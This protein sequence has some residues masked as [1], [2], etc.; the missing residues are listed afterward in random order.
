[1]TEIAALL[2][3]AFAAGA[4]GTAFGQFMIARP[5]VSGVLAGVAVGDLAL[6]AA[7]G[8]LLEVYH[9][10]AIPVGGGRYP[11]PGPAAVVGVFAG[12]LAGAVPPPETPGALDPFHPFLL[13]EAPG[14]VPLGVLFALT[15]SLLGGW[16]QE[17]ARALT[18]LW[19][20]QPGGT[21]L[22]R[23]LSVVHWSGVFLSGLRGAGIAALG[24]I[25][26]AGVVP[27]L[28][29]W[30]LSPRATWGL[31]LLTGC[32]PLGSLLAVLGGVRR[33]GW[34]T[35]GGLLTGLLLGIAL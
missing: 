17:K 21:G 34:W 19:L 22:S 10:P 7:V 4:D 28:D 16:A 6:G 25:V 3:L 30:P 32:I 2:A 31:L 27:Y 9:L 29:P 12:G 20:P 23:S 11:E 8:A 35:A 33:L 5:L 14:V 18:V 26:A 1:M 15:F 13:A 24:M